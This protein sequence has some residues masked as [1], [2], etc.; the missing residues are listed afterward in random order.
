MASITNQAYVSF[1]HEGSEIVK[2]NSSNIVTATMKDKYSLSVEKTSTNDC[3]RAGE[4]LTYFIRV[5]NSG[6][7]C[8]CDFSIVDTFGDGGLLTFIEGSAKLFVNG[9]MSDITPTEISPLSFTIN[10]KLERDKELVLQYNVLVDAN[11]SAEIEEITNNVTVTA[12]PCGCGCDSTQSVS[13]SASV[14]IP[15]CEFAEVLI[16]KALSN[17]SYCSEDELE[18]FITL[19]NTGNV[20]ATNVVVT[21]TLPENFTTTEIHMENNGNHYKFDSSEYTIDDANLLTL[22]NET[23]TEILVPSLA[24]GVDN[25]TR[26]RIRGHM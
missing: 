18:F 4:T 16:T 23:G 26:I 5:T 10:E 15:K 20:D 3:F 6:C 21:D 12:N 8:L 14:T 22:P 25:T 11:I 17:D 7:G 2:T 19:T 24:P 1:S 13:E 9:T